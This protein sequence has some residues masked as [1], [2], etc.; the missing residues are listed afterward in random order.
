MCAMKL[1]LTKI[2]VL[3]LLEKNLKAGITNIG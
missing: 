1:I 2:L 3:P